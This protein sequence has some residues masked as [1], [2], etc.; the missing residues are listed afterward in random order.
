M[1]RQLRTNI[2]CSFRSLVPK[3]TCFNDANKLKNIRLRRKFYYDY[4]VR[5]II[6]FKPGQLI[7]FQ[8]GAK[9]DKLWYSGKIIKKHGNPRSYVIEGKN[10]RR[11]VRN[12][13]HIRLASNNP[14]ARTILNEPDSITPIFQTSN[15][16]TSPQS[17]IAHPDKNIALPVTSTDETLTMPNIPSDRDLASDTSSNNNNPRSPFKRRANTRAEPGSA[18]GSPRHALRKQLRSARLGKVRTI[19]YLSVFSTQIKGA[20]AICGSACVNTHRLNR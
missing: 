19:H 15:D 8:K 17:P 18:R 1:S 13:I 14:E 5:K 16:K 4:N 2:P 20:R 11:Y 9:D 7:R 12:E 6:K 3:V 10:G